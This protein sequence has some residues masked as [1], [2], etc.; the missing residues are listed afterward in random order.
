MS[1]C[2]LAGSNSDC[3]KVAAA[4]LDLGGIDCGATIGADVETRLERA[5]AVE[6]G[7]VRRRVERNGVVRGDRVAPGDRAGHHLV[8]ARLVLRLKRGER[9]SATHRI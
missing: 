3:G 5:D 9:P 2:G 4:L 7:A 8:E 1:L 6:S